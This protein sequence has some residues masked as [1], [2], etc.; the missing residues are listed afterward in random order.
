MRRSGK[1]GAGWWL[2]HCAA[3]KGKTCYLLG[4]CLP[5]EVMI[6]VSNSTRCIALPDLSQCPSI[7]GTDYRLPLAPASPS[8]TH[9]RDKREGI[10]GSKEPAPPSAGT[11]RV[12]NAGSNLTTSTW[13]MGHFVLC[14]LFQRL[15]W[16]LD[17][18]PEYS[19][20]PFFLYYLWHTY[21]KPGPGL[22]ARVSCQAWCSSQAVGRSNMMTSEMMLQRMGT[23]L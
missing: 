16:K 20:S 9:N 12:A 6:P 15:K 7:R 8:F 14:P 11:Q 18:Y 4:Y 23:H 22:N 10:S 13:E 3:G 5:P 17:I 2:S 21:Y 1:P 19:L